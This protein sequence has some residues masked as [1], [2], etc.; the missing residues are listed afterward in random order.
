M[1]D[2][3]WSRAHCVLGDS[4]VEKSGVHGWLRDRLRGHE[5]PAIE[6]HVERPRLHNKDANTRAYGVPAP[7]RE[8]LSFSFRAR[9]VLTRSGWLIAAGCDSLDEIATNA[10]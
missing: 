4:V 7:S 1:S 8:V 6:R 10:W 9:R 2:S 5:L 3:V